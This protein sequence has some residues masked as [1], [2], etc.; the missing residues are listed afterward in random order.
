[1]AFEGKSVQ[2]FSERYFAG[3]FEFEIDVSKCA[4][5][6]IGMIIEAVIY[7][8]KLGGGYNSGYGKLRVKNLKLVKSEITRKPIITRNE[9]FII[10]E[11]II[12]EAIP[13]EFTESLKAWNKYLTN[14][15]G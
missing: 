4:A 2:N 8:Q 5:E 10:K 13:R 6:E 1:M 3:D 15:A 14:T 11:Q 12:E 7:M 9:D